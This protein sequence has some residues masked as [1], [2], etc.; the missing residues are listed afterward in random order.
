MLPASSRGVDHTIELR[1][2]EMFVATGDTEKATAEP[3]IVDFSYLSTRTHQ[4]SD[5]DQQ[6]TSKLSKEAEWA[7]ELGN[8]QSPIL[9]RA[10]SEHIDGF[11][12]CLDVAESPYSERSYHR[13]P[14]QP[15]LQN[16]YPEDTG[17]VVSDL[18]ISS[19]VAGSGRSSMT[20]GSRKQTCNKCKK[21]AQAASLLFRCT[22]CP[23]RYHRHCAVPKVPASSQ[24]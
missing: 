7:G 9:E 3:Q 22:Q 6:A 15:R 13:S 23:R 12:M 11:F 20:S 8:G 17:S 5:D 21:A 10:S 2:A 24:A 18:T 14:P 16:G 1:E 19:G 4:T